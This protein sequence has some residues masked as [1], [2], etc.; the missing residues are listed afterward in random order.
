M[1]HLTQE[2]F[3]STKEIFQTLHIL[4]S[5]TAF[6][7]KNDFRSSHLLFSNS[8]CLCCSPTKLLLSRPLLYIC[9]GCL[10]CTK[11]H[12]FICTTHFLNYYVM[13]LKL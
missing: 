2:H 1:V 6:W 4:F 12:L 9:S 3:R 11:T 10:Q 8:S 7:R 13:D 5:R